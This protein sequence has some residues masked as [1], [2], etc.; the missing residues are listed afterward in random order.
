QVWSLH[1]CPRLAAENLN[2]CPS[3]LAVHL[4]R[5]ASLEERRSCILRAP[6]CAR[7]PQDDAHCPRG[8][9]SNWWNGGGD[10]SVHSSVVAP[11][12]HG[13][14]AACSLRTKASI[15]PEVK[16]STPQPEM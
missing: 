1:S 6:R 5:R 14:S 16:V 3:S 13:L 8:S 10:G 4:H 15:S 2:F 12:P 11:T 7:A 9:T